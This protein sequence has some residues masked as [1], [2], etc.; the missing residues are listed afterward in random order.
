MPSGKRV[1]TRVAGAVGVDD[2]RL[3]GSRNAIRSPSGDQTGESGNARGRCGSRV[4]RRRSVPSRVHRRRRRRAAVAAE[5][6][7]RSRCR[8]ATSARRRRAAGADP[9]EQPALASSPRRDVD[10]GRRRRRAGAGRRATS[11]SCPRPCPAGRARRF[12]RRWR[13]R[14]TRAVLRRARWNASRRPS[15]DHD[16]LAVDA[17]VRQP[18]QASVGLEQVEVGEDVRRG[19]AGERD[20]PRVGPGV[21]AA[22]GE[23]RRRDRREREA[24]P[25]QRARPDASAAIQPSSVASGNSHCR[26]AEIFIVESLC[27]AYSRSGSLDPFEREDGMLQTRVVR[28]V[29]I[30]LAIAALAVAIAIP[31]FAATNPGSAKKGKVD[32]R[33]QLHHLPRAQGGERA[34]HDRPEP[35]PEEARATSSSSSASRTARASCSPTRRT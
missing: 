27:H 15:G 9:S 4:R 10:A 21:A 13:R 35:R 5:R 17:A 26:V 14:A 19:R 25:S 12:R 33:R 29:G 22:S 6:E 32:L 8:R 20:Q 34:R 16:R 24:A 30:G 18:P 23:Q 1:S 2:A 11:R 7:R 28:R 3:P 31:A